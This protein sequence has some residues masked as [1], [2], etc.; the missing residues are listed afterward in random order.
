MRKGLKVGLVIISLIVV[1]V[2]VVIVIPVQSESFSIELSFNDDEYKEDEVANISAKLKY[3]SFG[4]YKATFLLTPV[5]ILIYEE[6]ELPPPVSLLAV[7]RCF[8][9]FRRFKSETTFKFNSDK[10]YI[11]HA[12]SNFTIR[13]ERYIIE[14]K[15][16][17]ENGKISSYN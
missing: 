4:I 6:G 12:F 3:N 1:Y 17:I 15:L 7:E 14:E 2:L 16:K 10:V 11:V 8:L 9:P 5:M 13:N